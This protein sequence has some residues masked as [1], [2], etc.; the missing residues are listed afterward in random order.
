MAIVGMCGSSGAL[1]IA[2]YIYVHCIV[3][4]EIKMKNVMSHFFTT[5]L[6][7]LSKSLTM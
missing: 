2:Q 5:Q 1:Q 3:L 7:S 4:I 6:A